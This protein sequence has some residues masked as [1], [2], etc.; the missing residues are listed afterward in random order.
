MSTSD[1][2]DKGLGA[3]G[4][5]TASGRA[6]GELRRYELIAQHTRDIVLFLRRDDGRILEANQAATAAYG[7]DHDELR[8]LSVHDLRAP[9]TGGA[10][11]PQMAEAYAHGLLFE[12][13][14]RR[15]D[16]STFAVE[17]SSRGGMDGAT[18]VLV[19]VIRDITEKK[20]AAQALQENEERYRGFFDNLT[21]GVVVL[22]A[23]R[24]ASGAPVDWLCAASN[25]A[26][27]RLFGLDRKS[28]VGSVMSDVMGPA[29][30]ARLHGRNCRVLATGEPAVEEINLRGRH[31]IS[32]AFRI[33]ANTLGITALDVTERT[34]AEA[35]LRASEERYAALFDK[36]P[37]AISLTKMPEDTVVSVNEA[38]LQLFEFAREDV[39]GKTS[40]ELG[41]AD[42]RSRARAAA[43]LN[44]RGLVRDFECPRVTRSGTVRIL[45]LNLDW[46]LIGARQ[47]V[48]TTIRDV[49]EQKAAEEA[50]RER[51]AQLRELSRRLSYHADNSPLAVIEWG[52]DMRLTRWSNTAERVFGWRADEVL[53][54]RMEDFR[55]IYAEDQS[56]VEAVVAELQDGSNPRR[57][58]ANRNYRKDGSVV[59][60]EWYNSSLLDDSGKLQSILSLALDVTERNRATEALREAHLRTTAVLEAIADAFYSL[61][62]LWRFVAVNPAAERAP[63]GRPA[64]ELLGRVIWDVFPAIVGTPIHQRYLDAVSKRRVEHY[65]AASPLNGR[66]Y[67]VFMYPRKGGLD[68]YLRDIDERRKAEEA[69]READN[70]KN[71]FLAVLSHELRNPLAPIHNS[72]YILDRAVPGGEQAN[73][74]RAVIARQVSQLTRLVDDLL[75]VTRI[76]SGKLRL[77]R[78][79]FDLAQMIRR[80]ADDHRNMFAEAGNDIEVQAGTE[81]MWM[82]G[83]ESRMAQAT[84]NLLSNSVKFTEG[85]G[86]VVL[87]L[88][89]DRETTTGVIRIQDT[90]IGVHPDLLPRLFEPFVQADSSLDRTKSGL[91]L[92]LAL[93]KS[94]VDLHGGTVKAYSEGPGKGTAFE[95]RVPVDAQPVP[96]ADLRQRRS[97]RPSPRRVL[98]IEDNV[99][100]A[101]SLRDL[102]EFGA[103]RV[104]VAYSGPDGIQRAKTF[105]P[106]VV[107]CDIGLPGMD[108]YEVARAIRADPALRS[109]HLVALS[110]YAHPED[111]KRAEAAGFDGHIAKPA[112]PDRIEEV[113]RNTGRIGEQF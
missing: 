44:Q 48:L 107:F 58:S 97:N 79:R 20:R 72:L 75:D 63:F 62:D 32:T 67:E 3:A 65:E 71:R 31:I 50:V 113:L 36:S 83:D 70:Q 33:N 59:D 90:G 69:L 54:K 108:G 30:L 28:I 84:G 42:A 96:A 105:R 93:V 45:S 87:A 89:F 40:E 7:Y 15:K 29:W 51:E 74:A 73:R 95:I 110:G 25:E 76:V 47:H 78:A 92:G 61:D 56:R 27:R 102:L 94:V 86:R 91:G 68:V 4:A 38:F 22:E 12:T 37:F 43:E 46:V 82:M 52:P 26:H 53:G 106:D 64:S 17:V 88:T 41:I 98:V 14:H 60:C 100:A 85:G 80:T 5:N 11:A 2:D 13:I 18:P 35:A 57:F 66:W 103:H 77:Q 55:W 34:L 1:R 8:K 9:D 101:D 49:T 21:E 81:P 112:G 10:T 109:T 19:S 16:G 24:D 39:V 111:L 104:E 99:D 6:E 23:V